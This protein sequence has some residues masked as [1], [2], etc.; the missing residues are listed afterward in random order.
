[1]LMMGRAA[2]STSSD[3]DNSGTELTMSDAQEQLVQA[4]CSGPINGAL[5]SVKQAVAETGSRIAAAVMTSIGNKS[6]GEACLSIK[7][8]CINRFIAFLI[9]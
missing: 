2:S 9:L 8:L 7:K 5:V 1:M 4:F 3:S 6:H